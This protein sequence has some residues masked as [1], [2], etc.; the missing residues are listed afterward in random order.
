MSKR[1]FILAGALVYT[2]EP[3][4]IDAPEPSRTRQDS[5]ACCAP[6]QSQTKAETT[7]CCDSVSAQPTRRGACCE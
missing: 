4:F 2:P 3:P 1:P 6:A 7:K 5:G